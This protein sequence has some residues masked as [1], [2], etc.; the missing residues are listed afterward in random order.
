MGLKKIFKW[1][2]TS[3]TNEAKPYDPE[4]DPPPVSVNDVITF[5]DVS[6]SQIGNLVRTSDL[7]FEASACFF[8][9]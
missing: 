7:R 3:L 9:I 5:I 6:T 4:T 1:L 2:L 8:L